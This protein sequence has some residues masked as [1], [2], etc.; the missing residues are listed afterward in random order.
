[1]TVN[2]A[3]ATYSIS[4]TISN[5]GGNAATVTLS[6]AASATVTASST[7]T[8]TFSNLANGS[9]TVTPSKSGYIFT[10]A[11]TAVT[12]NGANAT[13]NFTSTAE[14]AIDQTVSTDRGTSATT[15]ASPAFTTTKTNELL[16]AFISADAPT[17]GTNTTVS[18]IAGGSLTWTLVKR[19][20][21]QLGTAEVW[22]A[23]APAVLTS[24]TVTATLSRSEA[25]SITVVTFAGADTTGTGGSG[26]IGATGSGNADPGAPTAS[27][28]TTRNNSWVFGVGDDWDN[29][30][31]RTVGANQTM[32]HQYLA[33]AIGDTYWVQRQ[34]STTPTSGTVVAINDTAPTADRYNLTIVEV[35][36]AQ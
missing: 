30:T 35:L 24:A 20:N 12:V 21:T 22:R 6:G 31:A 36:P 13:A 15:I 33:T 5:A 29:A 17:S 8:Y 10:P 25:A 28:T 32:V 16:L 14:L 34:T 3:G 26:A 2:P 18:S 9:Y 7:G 1:M 23:F 19:T 11:S 4:G 27:L